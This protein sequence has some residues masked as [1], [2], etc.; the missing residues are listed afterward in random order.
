MLNPNSGHIGNG[1]GGVNA[2]ATHKVNDS[3]TIR[4]MVIFI[5]FNL[6]LVFA[7]YV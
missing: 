1:I 6:D 4:Q 7:K 2:M 3:E 5:L